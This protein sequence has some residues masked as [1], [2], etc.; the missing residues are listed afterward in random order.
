MRSIQM[1]LS[2]LSLTIISIDFPRP[3]S[4]LAD[5]EVSNSLLDL[6]RWASDRATTYQE[7]DQRI[8]SFYLG[9]CIKSRHTTLLGFHLGPLGNMDIIDA[10]MFF[11]TSESGEAILW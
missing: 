6:P 3:Y 4:W 10:Y 1:P 5:T 11:S 7:H 9:T 8:W 2:Y